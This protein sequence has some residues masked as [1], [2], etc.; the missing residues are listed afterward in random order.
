MFG[1]SLRERAAE[2]LRRGSRAAL[3]GGI[4]HYTDVDRFHLNKDASSYLYTEAIAHQIYA[5]GLVFGQT[6]VGKE[7]WA[8]LEF[9]FTSVAK[10]ISEHE[11]KESLQPGSI[12]S[13]VFKRFAEMEE[14][15]P[16]NRRNGEHFNQSIALVKH[17]DPSAD[18]VAIRK[19]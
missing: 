14:L 11:Q 19:A 15:S 4:F 13:F 6:F 8:T 18:G 7:N 9:F 2:A 17:K 10:G 12:S 16:D 5:L 1:L 3:T